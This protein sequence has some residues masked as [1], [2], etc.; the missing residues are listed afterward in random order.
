MLRTQSEPTL[1]DTQK[2]SIQGHISGAIPG[3]QGHVPG[4]RCDPA[5]QIGTFADTVRKCKTIRSRPHYDHQAVRL[6]IEAD[7]L[8]ARTMKEPVL[9]PRFDKRGVGY[10]PAGDVTFSRMP[11]GGEIPAYR[12]SD[13]G[14]ASASFEG[15]GA[16]SLK[17][18]GSAARSI[19]GFHGF[20]PGRQAE[21]VI[22]MGWSKT[23]ETSIASHLTSRQKGMRSRSL[24]TDGGTVV[25]TAPGDSQPEVP[26]YSLSYND[27]VRGFS[28]CEFT[29]SKVD[30]AGRMAPCGRQEDFGLARPTPH[31]VIHGYAG[32]VPGRVGENVIGERQCKTNTLANKLWRKQRMRTTQR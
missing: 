3:Y 27:Q 30:P 15:R 25:P 1:V 21:N 32:W 11:P 26:L 2:S 20:V 14:L 29:G 24:V 28:T 6:G 23:N 31:P 16:A 13:L 17:G 18:Y 4:A 22:G 7:D 10:Q 5:V 19:P 8:R 9:A 12:H